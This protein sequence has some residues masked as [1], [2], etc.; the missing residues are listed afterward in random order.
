ML[1]PCFPPVSMVRRWFQDCGASRITMPLYQT[2]HTLPATNHFPTYPDPGYAKPMSRCPQ[3]LRQTRQKA[4]PTIRESFPSGPCQLRQLGPPNCPF[5]KPA[6]AELV[7]APSC[8]HRNASGTES[9][10]RLPPLDCVNYVNLAPPTSPSGPCQLCQLGPS[11]FPLWTVSTM[12]TWPSTR[13][14]IPPASRSSSSSTNGCFVT[15][16]AFSSSP[17]AS[18]ISQ[19][20]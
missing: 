6:H 16:K 2:H 15:S 4:P 3:N 17:S 1:P 8:S 12:S 19:G 14:Q 10:L 11:D 18:N 5:Q 13:H 9:A 20:A 7:E